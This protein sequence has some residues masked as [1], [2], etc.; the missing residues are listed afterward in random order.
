MHVYSYKQYYL[1]IAVYIHHYIY[2]YHFNMCYI[3]HCRF[4]LRNSTLQNCSYFVYIVLLFRYNSDLIT[5]CNTYKILIHGQCT[6]L[7][8]PGMLI[9]CL[10]HVVKNFS[11]NNVDFLCVTCVTINV[12]LDVS[13]C[14]HD[15][16]QSMPVA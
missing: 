12:M 10:L 11:G 7:F 5:I 2:L 16:G 13:L 15:R 3:I 4:K 14:Q 8:P 9:F 1:V 6:S